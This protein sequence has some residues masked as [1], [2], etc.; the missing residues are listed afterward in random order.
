MQWD[1]AGYP[2]DVATGG[3]SL[4]NQYM[5]YYGNCQIIGQ[6]GTG[7]GGKHRMSYKAL[8]LFDRDDER[9]NGTFMTTYYNCPVDASGNVQSSDWGKEGYL[10]Y[11][12][13]TESE[14]AQKN[15]AFQFFPWYYTEAEARA[16][17]ATIPGHT[18]SIAKGYGIINSQAVILDYPTVTI[19]P[20]NADGT[21][22]NAD[23]QNTQEFIAPAYGGVCVKKYDDA[24]ADNVIKDND[25][26]DIPVFH[27]S[28]MYLV[29]AEAYLLAGDEAKALA[30]VNDVRN[31]AK[32]GALASFGSYE[33]GYVGIARGNFNVTPLDVVLDERGR[34]LYAE[35]TRYEDLR[36]T[37]QLMRYN[38]AFS[39]I[40]TSPSQMQNSKGEYKWLRP[41]PANE[42][43]FNTSMTLE[44]QNPGY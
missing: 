27:V 44:D 10:A 15:I 14:L 31:R 23:Y 8:R 33:A 1:R 43:N 13:C 26:R 17:L 3:H 29:A 4:M 28:D 7:S 20:F 37:K 5:S 19:I 12:N 2:G 25:Y 30:K 32:A 16:A 41:I 35:R 42:I 18:K 36:R 22:G 9:F 21:L 38:L 40:I 11:F 39:R 24:E 6:K 34:E